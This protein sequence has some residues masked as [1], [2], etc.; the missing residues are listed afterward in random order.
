[1]TAQ[2]YAEWRRQYHTPLDADGWQATLAAW[3]AGVAATNQSL[4]AENK[5]L[6]EKVE[7]LERETHPWEL[8]AER[9]AKV[10]EEPVE[11]PTEDPHKVARIVLDRLRRATLL[12]GDPQHPR[13]S[14]QEGIARQRLDDLL[15]VLDPFRPELDNDEVLEDDELWNTV[16][17]MDPVDAYVAQSERI[18]LERANKLESA[19]ENM[20]AQGV[21]GGETRVLLDKA[22]SSIERLLDEGTFDGDRKTAH[23]VAFSQLTLQEI[24]RALSDD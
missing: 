4:S 14:A 23:L 13:W 10:I 19:M 7:K 9:F 8:P 12:I 1:V 16:Y 18:A 20:V 17:M 15:S 3:H 6:R 24:R 2:Q 5:R 11:Q 22:R 21:V